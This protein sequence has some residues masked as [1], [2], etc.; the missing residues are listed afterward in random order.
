LILSSIGEKAGRT[1][2][3][4]PGGFRDMKGNLRNTI[5]EPLTIAGFKKINDNIVLIGFM[6][7]YT[8]TIRFLITQEIV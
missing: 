3:I 6:S 1:G 2:D 4:G 8:K 5:Y 7:S